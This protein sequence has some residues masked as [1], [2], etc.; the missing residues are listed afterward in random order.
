[1]SQIFN[2]VSK[3]MGFLGREVLREEQGFQS[4]LTGDE[5]KAVCNLMQTAETEEN[6]EKSREFTEAK[7]KVLR[8]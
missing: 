2:N 6:G 4:R 5:P 8:F 1:M 7:E 3:L